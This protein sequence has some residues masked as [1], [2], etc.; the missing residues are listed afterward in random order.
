MA[1]AVAVSCVVGGT[2]R[3][4]QTLTSPDSTSGLNNSLFVYQSEGTRY[5]CID[6][7]P[8]PQA[9]VAPARGD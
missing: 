4:T 5:C 2:T 3:L 9:P 8:V 6:V 7:I 1:S